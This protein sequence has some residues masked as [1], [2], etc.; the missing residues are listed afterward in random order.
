MMRIFLSLSISMTFAGCMVN[1]S[2]D[3]GVSSR[4]SSVSFIG[5]VAA[6]SQEIRIYV[7]DVADTPLL[8]TTTFSTSTSIFTSTEGIPFYLWSTSYTI[9]LQHWRPGMQG[10]YAPIYATYPAPLGGGHTNL[11][12]AGSNYST[13]S[14]GSYSTLVAECGLGFESVVRTNDYVPAA[15]FVERS[16]LRLRPT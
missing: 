1:P 14:G 9:P 7:R 15:K 4:A 5:S 11:L 10:Y 12:I 2:A 6:P 13:C 8:S 16:K 3:V